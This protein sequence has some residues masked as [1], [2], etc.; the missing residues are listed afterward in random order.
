MGRTMYWKWTGNITVKWS[1]HCTDAFWKRS[2]PVAHW[3]AGEHWWSKQVISWVTV[4][5]DH[6]SKREVTMLNLTLPDRIGRDT[7]IRAVYHWI[8]EKRRKKYI[9]TH[10][11]FLFSLITMTDIQTAEYWQKSIYYYFLSLRIFLEGQME[12]SV[13]TAYWHDYLFN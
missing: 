3:L 2:V 6:T 7:W 13:R 11:L 8:K 4:V 9:Y 5:K 12:V 1:N 10:I